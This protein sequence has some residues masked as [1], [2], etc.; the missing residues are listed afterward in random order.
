MERS[1]E[2]NILCGK[3]QKTLSFSDDPKEVWNKNPKLDAPLSKI[4]KNSV[5]A[6]ED[7]GH[8]KDAMD[9]KGDIILKRAWETSVASLK[10]ALATTCVARNMEF[11]LTQLQEHIK[12]GTPREDILK[13]LPVLSKAVGYIADASAESVKLAAR[14]GGLNVAARRAIWMKTWTGDAASKTRLCNLPFTGDLLFGSG[15]D[16]AL[17]RTADKKKS[18]PTEKRKFPQKIFSGEKKSTTRREERVP[19]EEL[20]RSKG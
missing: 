18:F 7:M 8:L 15:L 3:S 13:T 12:N 19:E 11:W 5:L 17:E 9:K 2:K 16:E 6:F 20:D 10:P 4:S 1:R 14:S